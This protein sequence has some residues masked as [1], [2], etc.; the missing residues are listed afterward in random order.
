MQQYQN[1]KVNREYLITTLIDPMFDMVRISSAVICALKLS[2]IGFQLSGV[3]I[4][5]A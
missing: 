3:P 1:I 4:T 2:A 5:L